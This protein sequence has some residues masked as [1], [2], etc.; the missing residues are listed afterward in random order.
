MAK[1]LLSCNGDYFAQSGDLTEFDYIIAVDG[2]IRHLEKLN[3]KPD[4][5]VG[6][7][8]SAEIFMLDNN[9]VKD[10]KKEVLPVKKDMSDSDYAVEKAL[11]YGADSITMIGGIGTR[12]D[13][14]LFNVNM[15][16]NL[17]RDN[18]ICSI[19]DGM[20]EIRFLCAGEFL[21]TNQTCVEYCIREKRGKTLSVVP[22]SDLKSLCLEGFEYNL[23]TMDISRYSNRTLSNV[24]KSDN[25][26]INLQSGLALLVLSD[27][28]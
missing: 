28:Y 20:Q 19:H 7:M 4:L 21:N 8:D 14:S 16:L 5:W 13:H 26:K 1:V 25:A 18:I 12:F 6:D 17:A 27:G 10:I 3:I 11:E 22:F 9:F 23:D 24:I 15:F 2:G